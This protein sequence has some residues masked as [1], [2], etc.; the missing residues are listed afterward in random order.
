MKK[1][2][3]ILVLLMSVQLSSS[4]QD[5][6]TVSLE[7]TNGDFT[8]KALTLSAGNY[9]FEITNNGVDHKVGFVLAQK[10]KTDAAHHLKNAYVIETVA[11]NTT[12]STNLVTL[13]KG[14]YVYFCPLNPTPQYV[15]TVE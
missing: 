8:Q 12:G 3:V 14:D 5:V 10:G 13:T 6:K 11:K 9:Q 15:L 1:A 2:I 4:A 7:Q